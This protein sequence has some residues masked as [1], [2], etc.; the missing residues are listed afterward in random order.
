MV[1]RIFRKFLKHHLGNFI[2]ASVQ[3]RFESPGEGRTPRIIKEL[4][5]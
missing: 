5:F 2:H 1:L 3:M 4:S